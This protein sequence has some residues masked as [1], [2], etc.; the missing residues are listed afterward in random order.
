MGCCFGKA[1]VAIEGLVRDLLEA[2]VIVLVKHVAGRFVS[3]RVIINVLVKH[4]GDGVVSV[5]YAFVAKL[6]ENHGCIARVG[7]DCKEKCLAFYHSHMRKLLVCLA[8]VMRKYH[9]SL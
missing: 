2:V 3:E 4:V 1:L 8:I 6:K 9:V 7:L 5:L